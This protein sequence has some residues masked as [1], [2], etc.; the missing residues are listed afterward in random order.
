MPKD[1]LKNDIFVGDEVV[2]MELN[3]RNLL[4]GTVV[5]ITPQMV[6]IEYYDSGFSKMNKV[7]QVFNQVVNITKHTPEVN[8]EEYEGVN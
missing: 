4:K 7:K 2:F 5:R 6:V 8:I 3:Y 1:F